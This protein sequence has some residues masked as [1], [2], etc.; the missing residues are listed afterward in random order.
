MKKVLF[1]L[2]SMNIGGVEKSFLSLL[3]TIPK[4]KYE[5][6]LL[7][8]EKKGGFLEFIPDWVKIEEVEWYPEIKPLIMQPPHQ[9]IKGY[10]AE[11]QWIKVLTFLIAYILSEKIFNNR[12]FIFHNIFKTIPKHRKFYD[13]AIAYQGPTETIDYFV[14]NKI[15]AK[16][17]ISWV[18]FDVSKHS[19]N[20]K[21]FKRLYKKYNKIHVVS[22][23]GKIKLLEKIP[24]VS[25]KTKVYSNIINEQTIHKMSKEQVF[26]DNGYTGVKIVT[27]G[28]LVHEKGQDLAIKV[29]AR[30][31]KEGF[32]V[33]WYCIGEGKLRAAY[34]KLIKVHGVEEDFI[35]LGAM[36][37]PYPYIA[38]TDIYVQPSRFEGYCLTLAEAKVLKKPIV[39]TNFVGAMEQISDG[40]TGL[41][42]GINEDEIYNAVKKLICNTQLCIRFS[43][44]L[45]KEEKQQYAAIS[46]I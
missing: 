26:L 32:E 16:Q 7:L 46:I 8:L 24:T 44:N 11:K 6:T 31:R 1:M 14:A 10:I 22:E 27:V 39:T 34:E 36:T 37:N 28:R 17:K 5:I 23:E 4:E 45:I 18:H 40:R 25:T 42:V 41:I 3:S 19:L 9:T 12:I 38:Q 15:E 33:R 29:L 20:T 21:L 35:L 43:H 13:I 30:L 2:H